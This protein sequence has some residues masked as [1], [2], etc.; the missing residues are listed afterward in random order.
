MSIITT[1]TAR[2]W[3]SARMRPI[4]APSKRKA[5]SFRALYSADCITAIA[6]I[7]PN[8]VFGRDSYYIGALLVAIERI[9][10]QR[11]S[12][13][14]RKNSNDHRL[15]GSKRHDREIDQRSPLQIGNGPPQI[16]WKHVYRSLGRTKAAR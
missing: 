6:E 10:T 15:R 8:E 9:E 14:R 7:P 16:V 13:R 4:H 12:E 2:I 5:P 3:E 11:G 1:M